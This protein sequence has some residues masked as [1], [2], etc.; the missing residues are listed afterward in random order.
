[1]IIYEEVQ[2]DYQKAKMLYEMAAKKNYPEAVFN[3]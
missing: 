1:M 2:T 3:I